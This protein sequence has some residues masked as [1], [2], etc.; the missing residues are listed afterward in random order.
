MEDYFPKKDNKK[1]VIEANKLE[2]EKKLVS[3][4]LNLEKKLRT[5]SKSLS[6]KKKIYTYR[7]PVQRMPKDKVTAQSRQ[8]GESQLL[9]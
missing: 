7:L 4:Y 9:L 6:K 8:E 1:K 2:S 3:D 5:A